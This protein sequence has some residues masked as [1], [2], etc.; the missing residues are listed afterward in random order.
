[1][2]EKLGVGALRSDCQGS[3]SDSPLM[4]SEIWS[5]LSN[6]SVPQLSRL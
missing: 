4:A 5:K 6:F 2:A 1:M 3:S